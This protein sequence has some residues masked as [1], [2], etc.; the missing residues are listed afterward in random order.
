MARDIN[1]V[2]WSIGGK[3]SQTVVKVRRRRKISPKSRASPPPY[4]TYSVE[5][6]TLV[7]QSVVL[8]W[9]EERTV[10]VRTIKSRN[11]NMYVLYT[12][13]VY[14]KIVSFECSK[15]SIVGIRERFS[16]CS[17]W[18]PYRGPADTLELMKFKYYYWSRCY[19]HAR[20]YLDF[21]TTVWK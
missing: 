16:N 10:S 4:N 7:G 13:N 17:P 5:T 1:G 6:Y 21:C 15:T 18:N 19:I 20:Y 3:N 9:R 12:G 2:R 8:R 14:W 11:S